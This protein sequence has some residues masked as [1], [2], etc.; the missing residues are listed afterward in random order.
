VVVARDR[1]GVCVLAGCCCG[2]CKTRRL[3]MVCVG[4]VG[5]SERRDP[6]N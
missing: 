3:T 6:G 5:D 2:L 1:V 4:D